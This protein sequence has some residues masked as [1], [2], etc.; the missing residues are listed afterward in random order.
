MTHDMR[1]LEFCVCE[2]K[3]ADQLSV[4]AQ[5]I[6]AVVFATWIVQFIFFLNQNFKAPSL[7][8]VA[9]QPGLFWTRLV[10]QIVGFPV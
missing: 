9:V 5:L 8:S 6:K 2:N 4:S 3:I 1:N 7:L 10:T